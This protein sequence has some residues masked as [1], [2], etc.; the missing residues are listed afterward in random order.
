MGFF[1]ILLSIGAFFGVLTAIKEN[2]QQT[3]QRQILSNKLITL[4]N[5]IK[6]CLSRQNFSKTQHIMGKNKETGLAFDEVNKKI[7]LLFANHACVIS[8][9]IFSYKDVLSVEIVEDGEIVTSTVRS[10]QIG[11]ALIGGIA[12]GGLGAVIGGLSGKTKTTGT[13][14]KIILRLVV[15]DTNNPLHEISF[16]DSQTEVS[17]KSPR[18]ENAIK[19]ARHW[20]SLIEVLIK[21]AD[22]EDKENAANNVVQI[23]QSSIADEIK[24]LAELRDAGILS[25][26]EFQQQKKKLLG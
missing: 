24:K 3:K 18:Y 6:E 21:R 19:N 8:S 7:C 13:V 26:V 17:K 5:E 23:S 12:L 11:G 25:D 22:M 15:N 2:I 10:S 9:K 4:E 16:L 14:R 20:N 1:S